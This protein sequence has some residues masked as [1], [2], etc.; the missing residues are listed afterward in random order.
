MLQSL[1]TKVSAYPARIKESRSRLLHYK[2]HEPH[3]GTFYVDIGQMSQPDF[4]GRVH[5]LV[6]GLRVMLTDEFSALFALVPCL[7][8]LQFRHAARL[9]RKDIS[10]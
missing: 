2:G 7:R 3:N 8:V 6:A 10:Q 1:V 5:Y 9:K 4:Y